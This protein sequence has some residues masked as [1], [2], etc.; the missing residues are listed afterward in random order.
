[1]DLQPNS[2][3]L[4]VVEAVAR[5][6]EGLGHPRP[7]EPGYVLLSPEFAAAVEAGGFLDVARAEG[8]GLT[9]ALMVVEALARSPVAL[10]AGTTAVVAPGLG[11]AADLPR[12]ITL[13]DSTSASPVRHLT[14]E[15]TAIIVTPTEV[16]LARA[17][18]LAV[19]PVSSLYAYPLGRPGVDLAKAGERVDASPQEARRLWRLALGAEA[20]GLMQAALDLVVE[21]VK[22][23]RQFGQPLG[24]FQ[25]I[26]HRLSECEVVVRGGRMLV[27]EAAFRGTGAAAALAA[28]HIQESAGRLNYETQQFHGAI[29]LTLEYPLH[30]WTYRLRLLQGELGGP[31]GQGLDGAEGLWPAGTPIAEDFVRED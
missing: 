28:L 2:E 19:T 15:G 29:G 5:I 25:A 6:V 9:E 14:G 4:A 17:Q 30:Y 12:P 13:I 18:D 31:A 7:A 22:T 26:Q 11:L 21:H 20:V 27:L 3:Q 8:Y 1:M 23:R 10:E 24:V 16:R